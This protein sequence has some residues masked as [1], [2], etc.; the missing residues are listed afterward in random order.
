MYRRM[1]G[2]GPKYAYSFHLYKLRSSS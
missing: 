1:A 2:A